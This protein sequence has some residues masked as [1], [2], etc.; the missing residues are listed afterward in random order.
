MRVNIQHCVRCSGA[1]GG[2]LYT[3]TELVNN[4]KELRERVIS[5][6][7][8]AALQEFFTLYCFSG[9]DNAMGIKEKIANGTQHPQP[10]I[11][12]WYPQQHIG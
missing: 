8:T 6:D 5:G 9:D 11:G 4:M 3:L 12:R 7:V 1:K 10:A 2:Y